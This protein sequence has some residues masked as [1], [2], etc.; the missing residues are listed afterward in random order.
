MHPKKRINEIVLPLHH[1][2]APLQPLPVASVE[3][4]RGINEARGLAGS[5]LPVMGLIASC[6][7]VPESTLWTG[8]RRL[9]RGAE[10]LR[11]RAAGIGGGLAPTLRSCYPQHSSNCRKPSNE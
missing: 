5:G 4:V 1:L 6:L 9:R 8:D 7:L 2:P 10:R 11:V 3:E